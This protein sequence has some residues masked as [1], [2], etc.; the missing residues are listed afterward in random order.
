MSRFSTD[1]LRRFVTTSAFE[2]FCDHL[3]SHRCIT[4]EAA[5][6]LWPLSDFKDYHERT[7]YVLIA[8]RE[9]AR[10]SNLSEN[11]ADFLK[12]QTHLA[13]ATVVALMPDG[14][15]GEK[16]LLVTEDESTLD[17]S[18]LAIRLSERVPDMGVIRKLTVF[19]KSHTTLSSFSHGALDCYD[20]RIKAGESL[21]V[22]REELTH[23]LRNPAF[24]E[25]WNMTLF[26]SAIR[27]RMPDHPFLH[28]SMDGIRNYA[29]IES[30]SGEGANVLFLGAL[31]EHQIDGVLSKSTWYSHEDAIQ[32][33]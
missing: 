20:G 6:Q 14:I 24:L 10:R 25:S 2:L 16:P 30:S 18:N 33:W 17:A 3:A 19:L 4:Q 8:L 29:R 15:V 21:Q 7:R 32:V 1:E 31:T 23:L 26:M 12:I 13:Y 9:V 11:H 27:D 28:V 5:I 22:G